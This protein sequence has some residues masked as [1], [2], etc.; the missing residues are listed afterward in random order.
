MINKRLH[1]VSYSK[2]EY[3]SAISIYNS[4]LIDSGYYQVLSYE[5]EHK[6]TKK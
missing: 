6:E 3:E 2:E 4:A 5:G 1:D